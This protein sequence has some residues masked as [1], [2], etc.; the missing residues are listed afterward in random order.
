[1]DAHPNPRIDTFLEI[2]ILLNP[3][4]ANFGHFKD[5]EGSKKVLDLT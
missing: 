2:G 1:M 5:W 3:P 4:L